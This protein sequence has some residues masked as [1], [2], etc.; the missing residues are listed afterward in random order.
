MVSL[1][2]S[3]LLVVTNCLVSIGLQHLRNRVQIPLPKPARPERT[4][5]ARRGRA[6]AYYLRQELAQGRRMHHPVPRA[7]I[8]QEQVG[9]AWG[10]AE[11]GVLVGRDLVESRPAGVPVYGRATHDR[12][13]AVRLCDHRIDPLTVYGTI[14]WS[15]RHSRRG[16]EEQNPTLPHPQVKA[17][18]RKDGHRHG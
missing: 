17:V 2:A 10:S 7:A 5:A 3:L 18:F 13:P 4:Y 14:E 12:H 6:V 8:Q 1:I 9:A 11:N 15:S 16:P